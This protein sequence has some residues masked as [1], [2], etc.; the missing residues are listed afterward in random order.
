MA[1]NGFFKAQKLWAL[2]ALVL[3]LAFGTA[4]TGCDDP[5]KDDGPA[6]TVTVTGLDSQYNT[7]E[8]YVFLLESKGEG[9]S[10]MEEVKDAVNYAPY[11]ATGTITSG[12]TGPLTLWDAASDNDNPTPWTGS[13]SFYVALCILAESSG[14]EVAFVSQN[15]IAFNTVSTTVAYST[16]A[17][18]EFEGEE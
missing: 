13:G 14:F 8:I 1:K 6:K 2:G 15:K 9:F 18:D 11:V 4:V 5:T 16:S 3:V 12:S 10:D 17:F 7:K